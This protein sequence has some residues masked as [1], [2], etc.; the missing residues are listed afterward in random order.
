MKPI[1]RIILFFCLS[2]LICSCQDKN[3][4]AE[5]KVSRD[6]PITLTNDKDKISYIIGANMASSLANIREEIN[7][8]M[9]KKGFDDKL[10]N[11][12]LLIAEEETGRLLQDFSRRMQAKHMQEMQ[13]KGAA[14][15]TS[16]QAF[17]EEN[18]KKE[19][20]IT[21]ASGLQYLVISKGEGP[22]PTDADTVKV[23]YEGSTIDGK[24]FDSSYKRGQPATF[25]VTNVI[26]GWVE[27]LKLMP[28][29]SKY[30]LFVPPNLAYGEQGAGQS[31]EPNA[32]LIFEVELLDIVK[33]DKS[34]LDMM[35]Q[36]KSEKAAK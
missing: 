10:S 34:V 6:K 33:Q 16:G 18:A 11:Q 14:N 7:P 8:D 27:A 12:P 1:T 17:L 21:T 36:D 5:D 35:K 20:V 23:N 28:V 29:G 32:V 26:P 24:V 13:A 3:T 2:L 15:L 19:G 25:P 4:S 22:L 9:L 31:I 30:K